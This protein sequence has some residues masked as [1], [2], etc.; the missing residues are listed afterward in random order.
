[1]KVIKK[2]RFYK[3]N[4]G[5]TPIIETV[6][7][8]SIILSLI[9]L[10]F[11]SLSNIYSVYQQPSITTQAMS[12]DIMKML[13]T[14]PGQSESYNWSWELKPDNVS[15][16]GLAMPE[17]AA[18]GVVSFNNTGLNWT[19]PV[20]SKLSDQYGGPVEACFLPDTQIQMYD[21]SYKK[22]QDINIGDTVS[23]Y[24]TEKQI[25]GKGTV[26]N[27]IRHNPNEMTDYY[28]IINNILCVTP[29]H[30]LYNNGHWIH[31]GDIRVGDIIGDTKIISIKKVFLQVQTYNL[32]VYP[33]HNYFV[34]LPNNPFIVHNA[35][36]AVDTDPW[37]LT[38]KD[39]YPDYD[40][41]TISSYGSGYDAIYID[42]QGNIISPSLNSVYLFEI[43]HTGR[44]DNVLDIRKIKKLPDISYSLARKCLGLDDIQN[45]MYDFNVTI[46]TANGTVIQCGKSYE[47][48]N[49]ISSV[50][51]NVLIRYP[52]LMRS[53]PAKPEDVD[54][55]VV[56][57]RLENA[58]ITV[59]VFY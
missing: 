18:W 49:T 12:I 35:A 30:L 57:P 25:M 8:M 17:L 21:G 40:N 19:Y 52:P 37:A 27:I 56:S 4:T 24:N 9:A 22:I 11:I 50:T 15:R 59:Y 6:I 2:R 55:S 41:N 31:F 36:P 14:T 1:M 38:T 32:E 5:F 45:T 16:L 39:P 54:N 28:L 43:K 29:N 48:A 44:V 3:N 23:S 46:I 34:Y 47:G 10:F 26:T 42:S 53:E 58:Q 20:Y 13:I 7:A 51:K 33:Y